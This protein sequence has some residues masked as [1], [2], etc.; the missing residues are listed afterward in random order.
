MSEHIN[1]YKLRSGDKI[2]STIFLIT[3]EKQMNNNYAPCFSK[4]NS[5]IS[6]YKELP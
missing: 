3:S 2:L 1:F 5:V 6:S 4:N